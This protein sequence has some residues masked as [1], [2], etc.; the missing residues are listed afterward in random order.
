MTALLAIQ[1]S[2]FCVPIAP[3]AGRPSTENRSTDSNSS[4]SR[5]VPTA[6]LNFAATPSITSLGSP[7]NR[8]WVTRKVER[9]PTRPIPGRL[10]TPWNPS[11]GRSATL[12]RGITM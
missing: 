5:G 7:A 6:S 4:P 10:D 8:D 3:T 12:V 1:P 11:G 9:V 2:A